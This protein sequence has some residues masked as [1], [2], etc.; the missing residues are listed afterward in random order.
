MAFSVSNLC[1]QVT[2]PSP[3]PGRMAQH[4]RHRLCDPQLYGRTVA[5]IPGSWVTAVQRKNVSNWG[6]HGDKKR[7]FG[8]DPGA[9][10]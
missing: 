2:L 9:V 1:V 3:L 5:A 10:N 4:Q 7:T 6:H 8:D